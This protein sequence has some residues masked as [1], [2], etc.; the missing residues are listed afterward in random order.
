MGRLSEGRQRSK[1]Q[2]NTGIG[3]RN[4]KC[5]SSL[6]FSHQVFRCFVKTNFVLWVEKTRASISFLRGFTYIHLRS[7]FH[8][9]YFTPFLFQKC[10]FKDLKGRQWDLK[11][12]NQL[13]RTLPAFPKPCFVAGLLP[14]SACNFRKTGTSPTWR[15]W[16]HLL[17]S[18]EHDAFRW[19]LQ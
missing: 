16:H 13:L 14:M 7:L 6:R 11:I 12:R 17:T 19:R 5:D 15:L 9:L 18:C 1:S 10:D 4:R 8:F 3:I 2:K